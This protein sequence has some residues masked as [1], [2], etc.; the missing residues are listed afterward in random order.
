LLPAARPSPSSTAAAAAAAS[1]KRTQHSQ[2]TPTLSDVRQTS[3]S[4]AVMNGA[5]I[6]A[7]TTLPLK[8]QIINYFRESD[9]AKLVQTLL[10]ICRLQGWQ[11]LYTGFLLHL[12]HTTLR[13]ATAMSIKEYVVAALL[14][15][16]RRR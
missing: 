10:M 12:V 14:K 4:G 11:G 13:G 8:Q 6:T 16:S 2:K 3:A 7:S 1:M 5:N 9:A 15:W